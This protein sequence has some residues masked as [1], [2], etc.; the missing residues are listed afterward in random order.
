MAENQN[1]EWK[2][3]WRDEYLK[4]ICGFANAQG[5]KIYIGKNDAG[6]VVGIKGAKKL[7]EDIP[8]KVRDTMGITV[9]VN[10]YTENGFDYIEICVTPS[11]YPVSYRGEFHYRTGSTKQQLTGLAL[12]QFIMN[13]SGIR[14]EDSIVDNI[15]LDDVDEES[16]KIFKREAL[17]SHRMKRDELDVSNEEL[18][19][20][21]NLMDGGKFR[22]SGV[23]LFTN[24]PDKAQSGFY[25]KVGKFGKGSDLQYQDVFEGSLINTADKIVDVIFLKYLKAKITYEH[26]R[27]VET[28]P[29]DRDAIREAIYNALVHNF[30]MDAA[31]IQIRISDEDLIIYNSCILPEGWTIDTL[32]SSHKSMPYNPSIA[33]VFYR[34]GYI[35]NWGR[36]ITKIYEACEGLGAPKPEY[37]II[38][39]GIS[40]RFPAL[41]SAIISAPNVQ[42]EHLDEHLDDSLENKILIA[43]RDN[44]T[45][46]YNELELLLGV[47]RSSLRRSIKKLTDEERVVRIGGKRFGHWQIQ[48]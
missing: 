15:T 41:Q 6:R 33:G 29:Y 5:G 44:P 24:K 13:K 35:E 43:F 46:N 47:S 40:V 26:D 22:R 10:L 7:L 3:S 25:V 34:A 19:T 11:L 21:L 45:I 20:K 2:E 37:A 27:R 30:Y 36:G 18:L 17:K 14:W 31:P 23:L 39:Y 12:A 38:G 4:W 16:I 42:A 32:I 8:N 9:D 28:Y 48:D 1:I